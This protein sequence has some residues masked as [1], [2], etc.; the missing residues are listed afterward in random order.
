MTGVLAGLI[1]SM[2]G[3]VAFSATGGTTTNSGGYRYHTFNASG[4]FVVAGASKSMDVLVVGGG[5]NGGG[6][7][8][9]AGLFSTSTQTVGIGTYTVTVG[10]GGSNPSSIRSNGSGETTYNIGDT[11]PAGGIVFITPSTVGNTTGK[12]FEVAP[13]AY[14]V[15][16]PYCALAY[17][18]YYMANT[19]DRT[20]HANSIGIGSGERNTNAGYFQKHYT[21]GALNVDPTGANNAFAYCY[22]FS[23]GGFSDW[24]MASVEEALLI[25]AS[26]SSGF[27]VWTSS[28]GGNTNG[29]FI[30]NSV[31]SFFTKN[32]NFGVIPVRS[33][34]VSTFDPVYALSGNGAFS[35]YSSP[36]YEGNYP[37]SNFGV[38][39]SGATSRGAFYTNSNGNLTGGAGGSG[40][41]WNS[42]KT[43]GGGG[44]GGASNYGVGNYV[45]GVGSSGGGTGGSVN[46]AVMTNGTNG[47]ANSGG[48]GGGYAQYYDSGNKSYYESS[49]GSGG[50]GTVVVRYLL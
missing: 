16:R 42:F 3:A 7:G 46:G 32:G 23:Y 1:G 39:G 34:D 40:A 5:A 47:T 12:Y 2:K 9:G 8:G 6:T 41:T 22:N 19:D 21:M 27:A 35:T 14:R 26:Y 4:S 24:F 15:S 25:P 18:E 45:G 37:Y 30:Q 10:A 49:P 36:T 43:H 11:G 33:F 48:G 44:G 29:R 17:I 20:M 31:S 38:G 50:S 13:I 28:E